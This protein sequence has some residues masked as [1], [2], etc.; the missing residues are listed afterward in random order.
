MLGATIDSVEKYRI[1]VTC[2]VQIEQVNYIH[3]ATWQLTFSMGYIRI[4]SPSR[5]CIEHRTGTHRIDQAKY[6]T[7]VI[8]RDIKRCLQ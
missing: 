2:K 7:T 1:H 6:Y 4:F 8:I 5:L 3:H